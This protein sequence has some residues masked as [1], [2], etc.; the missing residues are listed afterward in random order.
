MEVILLFN[1]QKV[2]LMA[3]NRICTNKDNIQVLYVTNVFFK[4]VDLLCSSTL[5][6]TAYVEVQIKQCLC[7]IN[8][9]FES[10][11]YSESYICTQSRIN[12][13][14]NIPRTYPNDHTLML[15]TSITFHY[16]L[17]LI[18]DLNEKNVNG[19]Q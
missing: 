8:I 11:L 4:Y 1:N 10:K 13:L 6:N 19:T 7:G 9:A 14:I 15:Q 5:S 18:K 16:F 12:A 3:F 2:M 17:S